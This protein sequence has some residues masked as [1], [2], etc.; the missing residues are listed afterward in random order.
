MGS[1]LHSVGRG[2]RSG[3]LRMVHTFTPIRLNC[4]TPKQASV[5]AP[6]R[7][8]FVDLAGPAW[9]P[10]HSTRPTRHVFRFTHHLGQSGEPRTLLNRHPLPAPAP[11]SEPRRPCMLQIPLRAN[12]SVSRVQSVR[13][14]KRL[15]TTF[16]TRA[17]T[18]N[19]MASRSNIKV[20]YSEEQISARVKELAAEIK[21]DYE[22]KAPLILQV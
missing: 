6:P 11:R 3:L 8:L 4:C 10:R 9:P 19:V 2:G 16:L 12:L 14:F 22:D 7:R 15:S 18:V 5:R 21:N 1:A 20:L 17:G 13:P